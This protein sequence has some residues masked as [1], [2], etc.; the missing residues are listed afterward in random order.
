MKNRFK[1]SINYSA[2]ILAI[3]SFVIGTILLLLSQS[4]SA[5][6]LL[7]I[8]L[9]YTG[10]ALIANIIMLLILITNAIRFHKDYCENLGT[11]TILLL[12]IP[13][14]LYYI[15]IIFYSPF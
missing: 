6:S 1:H 9:Y 8:G 15:D 11:I 3:S 4:I 13:I 5:D 10:L 7:V 14:T 2:V 12:N